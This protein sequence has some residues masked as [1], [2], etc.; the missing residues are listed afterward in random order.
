MAERNTILESLK[1]IPGKLLKFPVELLLSITFFLLAL[2]ALED[3]E[4]SISADRYLNTFYAFVPLFVLTYTLNRSGWKWRVPYFLSYFLWVP[5]FFWY[6]NPSTEIFV[7]YFLAAILLL[8]GKGKK[9][10]TRYAQNAI[11]TVAYFAFACIIGLVLVALVFAIVMSVKALFGGGDTFTHVAGRISLFVGV[12]IVPML[13]C[14]FVGGQEP[15]EKPSK[16]VGAF[17]NYIFTPALLIYTV[18]LYAYSLKILFT[19]TLPQGGVAYMVVAYMGIAMAC[20]LMGYA[21]D[22]RLFSWYYRWFPAIS[23]PTV[24]LLWIGTIR[25]IMDYGFTEGRIYLLAAVV[26]L[27]VFEVLMCFEHTRDFRKMTIAVGA[28]ALVLTFIPG[29]TAEEIATRNQK[30]RFE[31]VFPL[32][33]KDGCFLKPDYKR[34]EADKDLYNAYEQAIS[35][36][37]YLR[38]HLSQ[39]EYNALCGSFATSEYYDYCA[40]IIK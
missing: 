9:D 18:I 12:V 20:Y 26:L 13:S 22:K 35:S 8:I 4:G 25:R 21:A 39:E 7:A 37:D 5:I 33:S 36:H 14:V 17:L 11:H 24:V 28:V 29:I 34:M 1:Q 2:I 30:A 10:N 15:D 32:V 3:V 38:A 23:A 16:V 40:G 19:W 27:T 6:K 31:E